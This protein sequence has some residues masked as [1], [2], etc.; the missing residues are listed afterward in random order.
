MDAEAQTDL[1]KTITNSTKQSSR[2]NEA[3][4]LGPVLDHTPS[5]LGAR[6]RLPRSAEEIDWQLS[7]WPVVLRGR[8]MSSKWLLAW[9]SSSQ[10]ELSLWCGGADELAGS[11]RPPVSHA[12]G[13]CRRC[14]RLGEAQG[15]QAVR[16][17]ASAQ[18]IVR[19]R[20]WSAYGLGSGIKLV[21][22]TPSPH[23][24]VGNRTS[25]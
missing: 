13:S 16:A 6:P 22:P 5:A 15:L 10:R 11:L 25:I 19:R 24:A 8:A 14:P 17:Q 4:P 18:G 1:S 21:A 2:L 9:L 12:G 7:Q 23:R 20:S 3:P